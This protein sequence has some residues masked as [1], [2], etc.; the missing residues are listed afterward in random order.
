MEATSPYCDQLF[1]ASQMLCFSHIEGKTLHQQNKHHWLY[2][3]VLE[4]NPQ[5]FRGLPEYTPSHAGCSHLV[6]PSHS[7]RGPLF[8]H[9]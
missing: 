7:E 4:L 1:H 9:R 5:C 2:C 6:Q 8:T 3:G